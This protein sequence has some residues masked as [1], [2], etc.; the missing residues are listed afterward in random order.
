MLAFVD[1]RMQWPES[2][3]KISSRTVSV[4]HPSV[5]VTSLDHI[6]LNKKVY[7]PHCCSKQSK[8]VTPRS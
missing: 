2:R 8:E 6:H 5:R 3:A 7:Y 4:V 1:I